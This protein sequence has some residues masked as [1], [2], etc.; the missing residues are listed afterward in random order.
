MEIRRYMPEDFEQVLEIVRLET[1]VEP[2]EFEYR[3]YLSRK[4]KEHF[5]VEMENQV[6]CLIS[7]SDMVIHGERGLY[8]FAQMNPNFHERGVGKA[9]YRFVLH[10]L[11]EAYRKGEPIRLLQACC[12]GDRPQLL[13]FF[14]RIGGEVAHS[15]QTMAMGLERFDGQGV[16]TPGFELD[17]FVEERDLAAYYRLE[18][19]IFANYYTYR[20]KSFE[21]FQRFIRSASFQRENTYV[22]RKAGEMLGF[23]QNQL[24]SPEKCHVILLGI[25]QEHR[26]QGLGHNL[27]MHSL[28]EAKAKGA[29]EAMLAVDFNNERALALY[30]H[31]GFRVV[32][33]RYILEK[34][35]D[36]AALLAELEEEGILTRN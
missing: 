36:D 1:R 17:A 33:Q 13:E 28:A 23:C 16:F 3:T 27:L 7:F 30:H 6:I 34:R 24:V 4:D 11:S 31:V 32:K 20:A 19:E 22:L 25:R 10:R 14:L 18:R 26:G 9:L 2:S 21:E 12:H 5:I 8:F 15:Y 29:R 35:F